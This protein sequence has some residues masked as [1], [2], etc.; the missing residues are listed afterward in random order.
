VEFKKELSLILKSIKEIDDNCKKNI[1]GMVQVFVCSAQ[2]KANS[3]ICEHF[4]F[5]V[6][7]LGPK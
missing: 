5:V 3:L 6:A 7:P 2:K 4:A 1:N